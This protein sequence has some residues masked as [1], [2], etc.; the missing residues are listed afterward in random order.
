V[1]QGIF[2]SDSNLALNNSLLT[3]EASVKNLLWQ[4]NIVYNKIIQHFN[5]NPKNYFFRFKFLETTIF[6][7]KE[8]AK[9]YKE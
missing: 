2:N 3:D 7:Y 8:L 9:L 4:L 5:T 6:N 1:P